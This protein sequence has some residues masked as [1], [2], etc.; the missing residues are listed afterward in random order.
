MTDTFEGKLLEEMT[1]DELIDAIRR[2]AYL[3]SRRVN[4]E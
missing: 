3:Y 2:M 4:D 1:K